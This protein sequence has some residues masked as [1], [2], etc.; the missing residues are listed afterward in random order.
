[1]T[2]W[3]NNYNLP[4]PLA[5]AIMDDQYEH[6]PD[7]NHYSVTEL[8]APIRLVMLR[9]RHADAV[10]EDVSDGLWRLLGTAVHEVISKAGV[11]EGFQEERLRADFGDLYVTGQADLWESTPSGGKVTDWKITSVWSIMNTNKEEWVKQV[12]SYAYLYRVAGF[13]VDEQSVYAILR[14]WRPGELLNYGPS[15]YP[16]VPFAERKIDI[17][18]QERTMKFIKGALERLEDHKDASDHNLPMCSPE[19]RWVRGEA[20]AVKKKGNKRA[21]RGG[22]KHSEDDAV[23]MITDLPGGFDKFE[24]EYRPGKNVR[25]EQYCEVNQFCSFYHD[26]VK[27]VD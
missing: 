1:M 18:P 16:A 10:T 14:D 20:W 24:V 5:R 23:A 4:E 15:K 6:N 8:I 3:T 22:V 27:E 11:T 19:D 9:R 21:E 2:Q 12:N 17:W 13:P 7:P 25:C 26:C